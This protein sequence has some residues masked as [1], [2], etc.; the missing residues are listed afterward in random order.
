MTLAE[1]IREFRSF[2]DA[3]VVDRKTYPKPILAVHD[4]VAQVHLFRLWLEV[5]PRESTGGPTDKQWRQIQVLIREGHLEWDDVGSVSRLTK[6]EA[7]RL[8]GVGLKRRE[9]AGFKG[10]EDV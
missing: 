6:A 10:G 7:S 1:F 8:I 9:G 5:K 3:L 2:K 4:E